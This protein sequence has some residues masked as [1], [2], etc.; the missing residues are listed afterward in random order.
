MGITEFAL[1]SAG[2]VALLSIL[3]AVYFKLDMR[4]KFAAKEED[5][6]TLDGELKK[7]GKEI[8]ALEEEIKALSRSKEI[9]DFVKVK[10]P[11]VGNLIEQEGLVEG[12][13]KHNEDYDAF[14]KALETFR[15]ATDY[16]AEI[17]R[18]KDAIYVEKMEG[19]Y[20]KAFRNIVIRNKEVLADEVTVN[21]SYNYDGAIKGEPNKPAGFDIDIDILKG[22]TKKYTHKMESFY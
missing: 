13:V 15:P 22:D 19:E 9:L 16:E 14:Q 3:A 20:L 2:V 17:Q 12:R 4:D 10:Y 5:I 11:V 18:L 7:R 1:I 8:E 21:K 6:K